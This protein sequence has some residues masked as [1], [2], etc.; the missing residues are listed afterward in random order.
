MFKCRFDIAALI[1][2]SLLLGACSDR[3]AQREGE[4]EL[5]WGER[6]FAHL[7]CVTCHSLSGAQLQGPPM[8]QQWLG[9]VPLRTGERAT[10]DEAFVRKSIAE[11][12]AEVR[13]GFFPVM[14]PYLDLTEG[15]VEALVAFWRDRSLAPEAE[16]APSFDESPNSN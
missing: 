7:G 1:V 5:E 4:T 14:L 2:C 9:P 12:S 15:Q 10:L 16:P 8:G 11:P 13:E 6:L 3:T